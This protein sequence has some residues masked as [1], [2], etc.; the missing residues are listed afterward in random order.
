MSIYEKIG[1]PKVINCSGK[2]TKLGVSTLS[3]SVIKAMSQAGQD[4]VVIDDLLNE[5]GNRIA[6]R[7]QCEDVCVTASASSGIAIAVAATIT[8]DNLVMI[9]AMPNHSIDKKEVILQK[10]HAVNYGAPVETMINLGGGTP[11]LVGQANKVQREHIEGAIKKNTCALMYIKSHHAVQKGM[12]SIEVMV[13]IAKE[14]NIP[15]IVDAAAE[16][17]LRKYYNKG[18]DLVIYSGAKALAGPASGF[19]SGKEELIR[20]CKMQYLGIGRAMKVGKE[21]MMGLYQAVMDYD[22]KSS[23]KEQQMKFVQMMIDELE[24]I[25]GISVKMM[26]DEAGREIYRAQLKVDKE[27]LGKDAYNL[28]DH[29]IKGNPSIYTR[30]HYMNLG[31]LNFDFR[32]VNEDELKLVIEKIKEF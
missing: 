21:N 22:D 5:V 25:Q 30:E 7:L 4:Y 24:D 19:I 16:E 23:M 1:L 20:C 29:L 8:E 13:D 31:I 2:M 12:Q 27:S 11:I 18:A 32:S 9:E 14:H 15:L 17:D 10:G 28:R 6:D 26:Q 3:E